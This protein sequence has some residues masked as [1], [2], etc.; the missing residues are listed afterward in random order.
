MFWIRQK[1]NLDWRREWFFLLGD[2][3]VGQLTWNSTFG[4]TKMLFSSKWWTMASSSTKC[5]LWDL[6]RTNEPVKMFSSMNYKQHKS[7]HSGHQRLGG[8][9]RSPIRLA[10]NLRKMFNGTIDDDDDEMMIGLTLTRW[11]LYLNVWQSSRFP[12]I[13]IYFFSFFYDTSHLQLFL[14]PVHLVRTSSRLANRNR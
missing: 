7:G 5:P 11:C 14:I 3:G 9:R 1:L 12:R 10:Q 6:N 2:D 8:G 4:R 13:S